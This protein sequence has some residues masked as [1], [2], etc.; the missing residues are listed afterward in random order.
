[1]SPRDFLLGELVQAQREPFGQTAVVDEDDRRAVRADELHERRIDRGPDRA[2]LVALLPRVA[3]L[4][5]VLDRHHDL[6]VELLRDARVDELD[7]AS[8]RDELADLLERALRRRE[9]D[10]LNRM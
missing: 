1:M 3:G 6:E 7:R 10:P 8:T 2:R 5:H 4:P 9:A